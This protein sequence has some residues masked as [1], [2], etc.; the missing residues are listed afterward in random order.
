[1]ALRKAPAMKSSFVKTV[2]SSP[3]RKKLAIPHTI[4]PASMEIIKDMYTANDFRFKRIYK[5]PAIS[6]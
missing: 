4:L 3:N 6:P 5:R 1:M 2:P